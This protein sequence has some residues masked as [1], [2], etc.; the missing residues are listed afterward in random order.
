MYL[1]AAISRGVPY[2]KSRTYH[3]T[4]INQAHS[5]ISSVDAQE[6]MHDP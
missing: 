6:V 3:G 5:F 2:N 4:T 1:R